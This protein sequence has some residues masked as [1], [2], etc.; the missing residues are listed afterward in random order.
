[1]AL[2][3]KDEQIVVE[4]RADMLRVETRHTPNTGEGGDGAWLPAD[5]ALFLAE[6]ILAAFRAKAA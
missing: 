1:M 3:Y 5:E 4:R 2:I 6:S